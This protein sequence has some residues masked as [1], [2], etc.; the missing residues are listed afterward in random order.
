MPVSFVNEVDFFLFVAKFR[1]SVMPWTD[2]F[3]C[4][5]FLLVFIF[6]IFV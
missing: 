3:L 6:Y 1:L 2:S 4:F 5:V